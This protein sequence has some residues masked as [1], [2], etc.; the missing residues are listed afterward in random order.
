MFQVSKLHNLLRPFL[1]RRIKS[2]VENSLPGKTEIVLYAS[3]SAD[4]KRLNEQLCD[5]SVDVRVSHHVHL[6]LCMTYTSEN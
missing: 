4:Q 5:R 2:D 3:M 1:L 6:L